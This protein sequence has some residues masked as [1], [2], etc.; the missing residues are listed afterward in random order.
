MATPA[1]YLQRGS[2]GCGTLFTAPTSGTV[3]VQSVEPSTV[4]FFRL[5]FGFTAARVPWT[6]SAGSGSFGTLKLMT[7]NEGVITLLGSTQRWT[8]F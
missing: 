3:A 5:D 4:P 7:F 8:T 6:D 2:L 1:F